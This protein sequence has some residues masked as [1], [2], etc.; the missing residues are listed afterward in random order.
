MLLNLPF[1][2]EWVA[3]GINVGRMSL[4]YFM[5]VVE[6]FYLKNTPFSKAARVFSLYL[7]TIASS[8]ERGELYIV[9]AFIIR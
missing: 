8:R 6:N 3:V 1:F 9:I 4:R 7:D 2:L 5:N